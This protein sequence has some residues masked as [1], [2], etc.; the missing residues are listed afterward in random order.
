MTRNHNVGA[1]FF[2][3]GIVRLLVHYRLTLEPALILIGTCILIRSVARTL[4]AAHL[5]TIT[6]IRRQVESITTSVNDWRN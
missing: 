5:E 3:V 6:G 1:L 2:I 4:Q